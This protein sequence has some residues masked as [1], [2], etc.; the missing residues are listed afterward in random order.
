MQVATL[1]NQ[2]NTANVRIKTGP[3]A[4][5]GNITVADP[6][7][8]SAKAKSLT[9]EADNDIVINASSSGPNLLS[10]DADGDI[11]VAAP[12]ASTS[13]RLTL[14]LIMI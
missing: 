2:L 4:G 3:G 11:L 12:V 10:L 8:Y 7:D 1:L 9:L 13:D 5:A 14:L 6:V